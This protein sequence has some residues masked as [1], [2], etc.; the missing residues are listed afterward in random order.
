VVTEFDLLGDGEIRSPNTIR[1]FGLL[2]GETVSLTSVG[3]GAKP[4]R[5]RN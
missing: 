2:E 4:C 1:F 3:V 5:L